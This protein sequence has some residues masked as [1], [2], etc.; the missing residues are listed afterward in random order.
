MAITLKS[1][2]TFSVPSNIRDVD[3]GATGTIKRISADGV[4]PVMLEGSSNLNVADD[5]KPL[6]YIAFQEGATLNTIVQRR[7]ETIGEKP[8][9][10]TGN[11][12]VDPTEPTKII[13]NGTT[14]T[15]DLFVGQKITIKKQHVYVKS[16]TDDTHVELYSALQSIYEPNEVTYYTYLIKLQ[17]P[18]G[19]HWDIFPIVPTLCMWAKNDNVRYIS[20][21]RVECYYKIKSD[22]ADQ[23]VFD[24]NYTPVG[25]VDLLLERASYKY[26]L[27]QERVRINDIFDDDSY[28]YEAKDTSSVIT[29]NIYTWTNTGAGSK[30]ALRNEL[31]LTLADQMI[32]LVLYPASNDDAE[33]VVDVRENTLGKRYDANFSR[34]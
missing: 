25:A 18:R 16:I 27:T 32:K 11:I 20:D 6:R 29:K 8:N 12:T 21:Y 7:I 23:I 14:F 28:I 10:L 17:N 3:G 9:I 31:D 5:I 34:V 24:I 19:E 2:Q 15:T 1:D 22:S 4:I 30:V 26:D 13:G 33:I